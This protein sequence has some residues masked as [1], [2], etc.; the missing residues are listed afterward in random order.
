MT[1]CGQ[2]FQDFIKLDAETHIKH[3]VCF[4]ENKE[5]CF[6][7]FDRAALEVVIDTARCADNNTWTRA[8]L[9]ELFAHRFA[10]DNE[11]GFDVALVAQ[12]LVDYGQDLFREFACWCQHKCCTLRGSD[13]RLYE[14]D[15]ESGGFAGSRLRGAENVA[16]LKCKRDCLFLNG[17]R[18]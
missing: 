3:T 14:R 13:Q 11:G 7:E 1:F 2:E 4:I 8:Q 17:S 6:V 16:A 18:R 10:A 5:A 9:C 15:A 12:Q